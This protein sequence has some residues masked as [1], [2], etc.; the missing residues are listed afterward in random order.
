M[1]ELEGVISR[2]KL[3]RARREM[4][5]WYRDYSVAELLKCLRNATLA[6]G[7]REGCEM[8]RQAGVEIVIASI[9]WSFAV[10]AFAEEFGATA[11]LGTVLHNSGRISHIWPEDK[12]RWLQAEL[13]RRGLAA[14]SVAAV[15]DSSGDVPMLGVAGLPVFVGEERLDGL[16]ERT[17]HIPAADQRDV[18]RV[19]L[20]Y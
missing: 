1:K 7:A 5:L 11:W 10:E 19:I 16:P 18:A 3:E 14:E 9:T 4:S 13:M 15:G 2:R 20:Q 6:P 12:A 17:I 8:L